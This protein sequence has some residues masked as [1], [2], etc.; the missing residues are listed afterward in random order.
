MEQQTLT[1]TFD[2]DCVDGLP[3]DFA[4]M[5]QLHDE[6]EFDEALAD[7]RVPRHELDQHKAAA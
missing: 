4:R 3:L 6:I 1:T 5:K 2:P 7:D